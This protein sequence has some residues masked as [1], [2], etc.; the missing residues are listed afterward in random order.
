MSHRAVLC[1]ARLHCPLFRGLIRVFRLR[2]AR[3]GARVRYAGRMHSLPV[4][5]EPQ[6]FGSPESF[7]RHLTEGRRLLSTALE[8][9]E[10]SDGWAVRLPN[11]DEML[12]SSVCWTVDER[13]CCPFF[14][15]VIEREP[16]PGALWVRITG[17]AEAKQV[18]AAG[19]YYALSSRP[20]A[21]KEPT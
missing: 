12:L 17:P 19:A 8:K 14:T 6:A 7:A 9:C 21:H 20:G 5:C 13:R 4:A 11:E 16:A 3:G 1:V 18:L 15:F 2:R 10:L